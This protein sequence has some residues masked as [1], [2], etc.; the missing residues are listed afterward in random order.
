MIEEDEFKLLF[1]RIVEMYQISPETAS[2][3]LK[4][5]LAILANSLEKD[6]SIQI[7]LKRKEGILQ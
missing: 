5:I 2:E 1:Q 6:E 3:L 4:R 7:K